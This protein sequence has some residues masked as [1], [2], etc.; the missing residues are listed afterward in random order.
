MRGDA[1]ED[2]DE[3]QP[4]SP[5]EEVAKQLFFLKRLECIQYSYLCVLSIGILLRLIEMQI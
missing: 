3:Q 1:I 2:G 4:G 5:T